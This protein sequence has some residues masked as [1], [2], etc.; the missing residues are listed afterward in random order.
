MRFAMLGPLRVWDGAAWTGLRAAQPRLLLAV[1]LIE[2]G[3][4]VSTE[5]LVDE[6]WG[7]RPPRAA[8]SALR[9]YVRRLRQ[10]LGGGPDGPLVT[11]ERGYELVV[12]E[13]ETDAH[14]FG[15][16]AESGRRSLA[17]GD[18]EAGVGRLK[19]G[20]AL[21]RGPALADV[22]GS[23]V[24]AS[25]TTQMERARLD[26]LEQRLGGL[27]ELGRHDGIVA[28]LQGLVA[29][30]PLREELRAQLMLALCPTAAR[31][32]CGRRAEALE[33]YHH[34]RRVLVDELGLE[35]GPR[36]QQLQR[37]MLAD[38]PEL[39]APARA[40]AVVADP[41]RVTPAQLP[42]EVAGFTGR[43]EHLKRLDA[44]LPDPGDPSPVVV[45]STI[46]GTAGVG[47]TALAI[48]CQ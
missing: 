19:E 41:V 7:E 8:V 48:R 40:G 17:A 21:W 23:P 37:Q 42:A 46:A 43:T 34:C 38:D 32:R 2:A 47:K 39:A 15:L 27:L 28:E 33:V 18:H 22:P 31:D 4:V 1:L 5:R 12:A 3:W 20:L 44:L 10:L 16:L 35:P 36:L 45:I 24:V 6:L 11:R 14:T 29:E 9:G 30:H 13:G 26:S 25:W